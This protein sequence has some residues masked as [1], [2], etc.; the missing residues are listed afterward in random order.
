MKELET[1]WLTVAEAA[2]YLRCGE[3]IVREFVGRGEIPH[4]F[5]AGKALFYPSRLDEFLLAQEERP[6]PRETS[7]QEQDAELSE[8]NRRIR[9]ECSRN[10]VDSLIGELLEYKRGQERFVNGLGRNLQE[11]LSESDYSIL[12]PSVFAQ[13][14]RWCHTRKRSPRND[15]AQERAQKISKSMFGKVIDRVSLP[16]YRS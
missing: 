4:V 10:E 12:S 3:R 6:K 16:S 14:S 1:N 7:A 15:W 13:L 5:F 2:T 9:L 8:E 11:D